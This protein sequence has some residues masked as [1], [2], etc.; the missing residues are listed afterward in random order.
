MIIVR[1]DPSFQGNIY[2]HYLTLLCLRI[3]VW[4]E[5]QA[6]CGDF[7]V[8]VTKVPDSACSSTYSY[9]IPTTYPTDIGLWWFS[10]LCPTCPKLTKWI[11]ASYLSSLTAT[12][13]AT[14]TAT[15]KPITLTNTISISG[16]Q[17][18][19]VTITYTPTATGTAGDT[20][21]SGTDISS[22]GKKTSSSLSQGAKIGIGVGAGV[23]GLAIIGGI[24]ALI[25]YCCTRHR[26]KTNAA[27]AIATTST[28]AYTPVN[29]V[30]DDKADAAVIPMY[31]ELKPELDAQE[32]EQQRLQQQIE[33]LQHQLQN[34]QHNPAA[35]PAS[36]LPAGLAA[37][38]SPISP[39]SERPSSTA[40]GRTSELH[41]E[42]Q[43]YYQYPGG[44]Q[45]L[46]GVSPYQQ[47]Y[48]YH[49]GVVTQVEMPGEQGQEQ[50]QQE[51]MRYELQ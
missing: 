26:R 18:T 25:V 28:T 41:S 9:S 11:L 15:A 31:N 34:Q 27:G 51:H 8:T 16:G 32:Q 35:V 13:N 50:G 2:N 37:H 48:Q 19:T 38:I 40:T 24:I 30:G 6:F 43:G 7:G 33:Q 36:A 10:Q 29:T 22:N 23:G 3:V 49:A 5:S 39:I 17:V 12:A 20:S 47:Q 42:S 4:E 21:T 44:A 1:S 45:E 46:G 14:A